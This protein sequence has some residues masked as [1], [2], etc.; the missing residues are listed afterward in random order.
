MYD[1]T[2]KVNVLILNEAREEISKSESAYLISRDEFNA[3]FGLH[4]KNHTITEN[5]F[6]ELISKFEDEILNIA[7]VTQ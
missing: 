3:F 2:N 1:K 6:S 7:G 4:N 5:E